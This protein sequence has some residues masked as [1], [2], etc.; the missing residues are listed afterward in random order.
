[1]PIKAYFLLTIC[2]F[3]GLNHAMQQ[4]VQQ[5]V[6]VYEQQKKLIEQKKDQQQVLINN[7]TNE[8]VVQPKVEPNIVPTKINDQAL[9]NNLAAAKKNDLLNDELERLKLKSELKDLVESIESNIKADQIQK[10]SNPIIVKSDISRQSS[11]VQ[12]AKL[13]TT[14]QNKPIQKKPEC[15][16]PICFKVDCPWYN[17]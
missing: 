2:S 4:Q 16:C 7:K 5:Q 13:D 9:N 6:R 15:I 11:S 1:M 17:L 14:A 10:D 3:F 12:S 8:K